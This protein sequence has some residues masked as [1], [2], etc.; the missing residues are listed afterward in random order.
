MKKHK[1][2]IARPINPAVSVAPVAASAESPVA[3][4]EPPK[5]TVKREHL[6]N[7]KMLAGNEDLYHTVIDGGVKKEWASIGWIDVGPATEAD[8]A[9]F[10]TVVEG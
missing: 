1:I 6:T 8:V 3:P 7:W 4:V 10:P 2:Y 5:L 9:K